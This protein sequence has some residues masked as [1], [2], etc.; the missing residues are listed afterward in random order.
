ML[1]KHIAIKKGGKQKKQI[2]KQLKTTSTKQNTLIQQNHN[3]N[4]EKTTQIEIK[5]K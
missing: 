1:E 3:E 4:D 5:A 2:S